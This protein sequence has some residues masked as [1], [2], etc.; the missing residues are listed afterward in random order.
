MKDLTKVQ[1]SEK[2]RGTD[3]QLFGKAPFKFKGWKGICY[4]H[5]LKFSKTVSF[6]YK[7]SI[8][9][10]SSTFQFTLKK[11]TTD[12]RNSLPL[13]QSSEVLFESLLAYSLQ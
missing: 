13:F 3:T 10:N 1:T 7:E 2:T 12:P 9:N 6:Y 11:F 4:R 5:Q 8:R